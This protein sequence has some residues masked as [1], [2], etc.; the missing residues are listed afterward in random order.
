VGAGKFLSASS[1]TAGAIFAA[2]PQVLA[3]PVR[4]FF[5]PN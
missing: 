1:K 4:V 3:T 5:F 2:Q